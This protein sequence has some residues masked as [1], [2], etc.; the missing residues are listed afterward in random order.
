MENLIDNFNLDEIIDNK[1]VDVS[2]GKIHKIKCKITICKKCVIPVL[3]IINP[4]KKTTTIVNQFTADSYIIP[5]FRK[6]GYYYSSFPHTLEYYKNDIEVT[7]RCHKD[8]TFDVYVGLKNAKRKFLNAV[9]RNLLREVDL[10]E[11]YYNEVMTNI[12]REVNRYEPK[13][14]K[15]D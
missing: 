3:V 12:K 6:Y 7:S 8:D 10:M 11:K 13:P 9:H 2:D 15:R 4:I 5:I 14:V 1:K